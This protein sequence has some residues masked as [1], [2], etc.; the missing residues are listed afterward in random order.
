ML[1]GQSGSGKST[2]ASVLLRLLEP[3]SGTVTVGDQ[4]LDSIEQESW[5]KQIK[6]R[7][8]AGNTDGHMNH[9]HVRVFFSR[10]YIPED[11]I[12]KYISL[13]HHSTC[14]FPER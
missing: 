13:L 14:T 12:R 2:T 9:V 8:Q 1:R 3:T 6:Q 10:G 11:R 5:W 4:P 7:L